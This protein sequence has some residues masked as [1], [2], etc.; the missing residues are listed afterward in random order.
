MST[1]SGAVVVAFGAALIVVSPPAGAEPDPTP[2]PSASTHLSVEAP[3]PPAPITPSTSSVPS[4]QT[5]GTGAPAPAPAPATSA[6]ATSTASVPSASST[7]TPPAPSRNSPSTQNSPTSA[8]LPA[9]DADG[10]P[11]ELSSFE[12][13]AALCAVTVLT[14][15]L[16]LIVLARRNRRSFAADEFGDDERSWPDAWRFV[17]DDEYDTHDEDTDDDDTLPNAR[18]TRTAA[19]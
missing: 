10:G 11:F 9:S 19:R 8:A 13:F 4:A 6:P 12:K 16:S 1:R 17:R 5:Y 14:L 2:I 7:S 15:V 18:S 3:P